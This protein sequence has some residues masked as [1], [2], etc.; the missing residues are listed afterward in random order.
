VATIALSGNL[1]RISIDPDLKHYF[2]ETM[3]SMVNTEKIEEVFGNQDMLMLLFEKKNIINK[4]SLTRI[5]KVDRMLKRVKGVDKTTSLFSSNHIYGE[6]GVMYVDPAVKRIPETEAETEELRKDI[7]ENDMVRNVVVAEDF[8][9]SAILITLDQDVNEDS[10]FLAINQVLQE[11]P[12][13]EKVHFGGLPYLRQQ[14]NKDIRRDGLILVPL[15][16]LIMVVFLLLVFREMRGVALPF[17]VVILSCLAA[18]SLLPLLGWKFYFITLLVPVMLIAIANDYGIHIMAKYQEINA[19]GF[20]MSMKQI[21]SMIGKKLWRPILLT[22]LTTIAG[23]SALLAHTMIPARQMALIAAVGISLALAYSIILLPALLSL[24]KRSHPIKSLVMQK[25]SHNHTMLSRIA[26]FITVRY[27]RIPL[28]ALII[29]VLLGLGIIFLKVD[30]NEENFFPEKHPVKQASKLINQHY[31]GSETLSL[32]FSGD[33]LDPDMLKKIENYENKLNTRDEID[34]IMSFPDVVLEISK[35]LNDPGDPLYDRIPDSRNAVAQYMELYSMNGDPDMLDQLVDFSY[36]HSHMMIRINDVTNTSINSIIA[37]IREMTEDDPNVAAIGGYGFVRAQLANKVVKGQFYS[38]AIALV[39][40]VLMVSIIFRSLVAG[41]LSSIPLT[42]SILILFGI[43]GL[44]GINLD[45][46][47]A[48]L[49]SVMIGVGV[50]YTIHFLWR[51]RE[52]RELQ[53]KPAE[54]IRTTLTTTGRGIT[55]NALSVIVGFVVLIF[56]S[57]TP[58]R[59][60]GVLIIVSIFTCLVGALVVLPS[61]VLR[62]RFSFLEKKKQANI[63]RAE[64]DL[65]KAG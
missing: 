15:A 3:E 52:E 25:E 53:K 11:N 56:S 55:F 43:M 31:G 13:T 40:I 20:D 16:L 6:N 12:G 62:F 36:E 30:S 4:E 44:T 65:K 19:M 7:L 42:M 50:D 32:M 21:A 33:M 47:T 2:P 59:F 51:Y 28:T 61:L 45:V 5:K 64:N 63:S 23:I 48:L 26:H 58:I 27:R 9:S 22:G 39:V 29:T 18:L 54:A 35:A 60:F 10:L 49:S 14:M 34:L 57:F 17:L 41:L 1:F 8:R 24:L 38:L 46:A 37:Q